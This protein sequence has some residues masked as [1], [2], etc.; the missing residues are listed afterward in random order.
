MFIEKKMKKKKKDNAHPKYF[1][2][3][4]SIRENCSS[5]QQLWDIFTYGFSSCIP[6]QFVYR[7]GTRLFLV[8]SICL[9]HHMCCIY[10]CELFQWQC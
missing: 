1:R 4:G 10:H 9:T 2:G 6:L 7:A 3:D 8:M 5:E